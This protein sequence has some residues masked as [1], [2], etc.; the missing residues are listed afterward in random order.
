MVGN[1]VTNWKYDTTPAYLEMG[2]WHSLYDTKTYKAMKEQK[3]DYSGVNFDE[4]PSKECTDMLEKFENYVNKVNVYNIF[5]FCYGLTADENNNNMTQ[6]G[7]MGFSVVNGQ[8]KTF[9]KVFTADDYTPWATNKNLKSK[10]NLKETPP[11][12]NGE[13]ITTWMN[14]ADVRAALGIPD[15]YPGW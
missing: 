3:C 12:V 5:G 4:M 11:C 13:Y 14:R 1:G 9:K 15:N 10:Q 6:A 8:I 7:D 2:F